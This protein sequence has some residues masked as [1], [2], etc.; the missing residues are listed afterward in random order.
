[1]E[2][3][4][5]DARSLFETACR[6]SDSGLP[7]CDLA[8][9]VSEQ[10]GIRVMEADGWEL[11]SLRAHHGAQAVYRITRQ[12]GSVKLQGRRGAMACL[13]HTEPPADI[14]RQL[15]NAVPAGYLQSAGAGSAALLPPPSREIL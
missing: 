2:A 14:A 6:A 5:T 12:G 4:W 13:L 1:V 3:F 9:L 11:A 10:A 8:I 7:D 15:L